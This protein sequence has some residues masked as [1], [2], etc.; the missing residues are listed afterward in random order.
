MNASSPEPRPVWPICILLAMASVPVGLSVLVASF[1]TV[2]NWRGRHEWRKCQAELKAAGE[3]LDWAAYVPARA[4]DDQNFIKT[5][6][7]EAV[8]YRGRVSTNVLRLFTEAGKGLDYGA[9][10]SAVSGQKLDWTNCQ[11]VLRRQDDIDLPPLPQLPAADYLHVLRRVEPQLDELRAASLRRFAQFDIDRTSPFEEKHDFNFVVVRQLSH[12]LTFHACAEV[13]M[14]HPD[15]AAAD[16]RVIHRLAEAAQEETTLVA[17]MISVALQ[18]LAMQPFWEGWTEGRWTDRELAQFQ[19]AFARVDLLPAFSRVMRAERAG[20]NAL[21]TKYGI[22]R[23]ELWRFTMMSEAEPRNGWDS[24]R[25]GLEKLAW[26]LVPKGWVCQNL[27]SYNRRMQELLPSSLQAQ[28]PTVSPAGVEQIRERMAQLYVGKGKAWRAYGWLE[29]LAMPNFTKA[30]EAV[31]RN[32]TW[33]NQARVVCALE[34][35]RKARGQYPQ[36]LSELTPAFL[37]RLP[38]DVINGGPLRYRLNKDDN[39]FLLYSVGWNGRDDG[40]QP[41]LTGD[42]PPKPDWARGDWVWLYPVQGEPR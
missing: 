1:Y 5:P 8:V 36:T 22:D 37:D 23:N 21:V 27:A 13:A 2:E 19:E 16:V 38:V 33:V 14:K 12:L 28:P 10:G 17:M 25:K 39:R 26:G 35:F 24:S 4:P 15:R 7:L 42:Y 31:A 30:L 34:R 40:G 41:S 29:R 6:V 18:G 3:R 9:L 11:T 32:Q 20:I